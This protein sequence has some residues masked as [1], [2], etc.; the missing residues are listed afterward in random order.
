MVSSHIEH[1]AECNEAWRTHTQTIRE[2]RR[3]EGRRRL[4]A[5]EF[6]NS[7]SGE[8]G[9]G[10][11]TRRR[12]KSRARRSPHARTK[13]PAVT[14]IISSSATAEFDSGSIF[15]WPREDDSL[16]LARALTKGKSCEII[17]Q[18]WRRGE[19]CCRPRDGWPLMGPS[20]RRRNHVCLPPSFTLEK[21]G[22]WHLAAI[23]RERSCGGG[24][25][26]N[27]QI[28]IG[29]FGRCAPLSLLFRDVIHCLTAA[30]AGRDGARS[31]RRE[32]AAPIRK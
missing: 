18:N 6:S 29:R 30:D 17:Q 1:G 22:C 24:G 16:S 15:G 9:R 20:S 4:I 26:G 27:D 21:R 7:F 10:A 23:E 25:G 32:T 3:N 12:K 2:V 13:L 5:N 14:I 11:G 28:R 31:A 8:S 19:R